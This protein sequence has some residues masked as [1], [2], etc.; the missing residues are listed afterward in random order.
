LKKGRIIKLT[1]GLYTVIDADGNRQELK[2]L[3]I[4]R[5]QDIKPKVGDLVECDD[6]S[7]VK[8]FPRKNDLSRPPIANVDQALIIQ[9]AKEPGF[10]LP[11]LDRFLVVIAASEVD[12]VIIVTKTDLL[13]L[14]ERREL[15]ETMAFYSPHYPVIWFSTRTHEGQAEIEA[16]TRSK[17]NVLTGQTGAGKSSLLNSLNPDLQLAT[18]IISKALGRGK[19]TTRT[20]ELISFYQGWIADTPGFSQLD[21]TGIDTDHLRELF[22]EFLLYSSQCRFNGCTHLHEPDCQVRKALKE[23]KILR[24]RYENYADFFQEI[25]AAKPRY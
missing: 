22:P 5:I 20:V 13:T 6:N 8:V 4:F 17:V 14:S 7:I 3:G 16:I 24:Q 10:S 25:H 15:E 18:D 11:L 12:P 19:H 23:N 9:S 21:I 1:G 2:P